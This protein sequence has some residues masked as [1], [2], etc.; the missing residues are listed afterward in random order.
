MD[1]NRFSVRRLEGDA[2]DTALFGKNLRILLFRR[3]P[4]YFL[5]PAEV[6]ISG[7]QLNRWPHSFHPA[8]IQPQGLVAK[9]FH[10]IH[11]MAAENHGL[12]LFPEQIHA[13]NAFPLKGH[14]PHGQGL[15]DNQDVRVHTRGDGESKTHIHPR[16][17]GL[18]RSIDKFPQS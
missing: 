9:L 10:M 15:V 14:V 11:G 5:S 2:Q 4:R 8:M 1:C 6:L 7:H 13:V 16:R 3:T 18:H 12:A 17:I